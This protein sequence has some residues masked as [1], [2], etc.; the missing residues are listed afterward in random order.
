MQEYLREA[1]T[2]NVQFQYIALIR[3]C[4]NTHA[5]CKPL[6]STLVAAEKKLVSMQDLISGEHAKVSGL[7]QENERL[8]AQNKQIEA[9]KA[10][11]ERL[12]SFEQE[13]ERLRRV[14]VNPRDLETFIENKT[15]IRHYLKLVPQLLE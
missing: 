12:Q 5:A 15:A 3:Y 10:E 1:T 14:N 13:I 2:N 8:R 6:R 11:I 9:M 7:Q 4:Q